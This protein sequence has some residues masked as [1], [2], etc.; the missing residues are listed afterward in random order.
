VTAALVD[1]TVGLDP[2][3]VSARTRAEIARRLVDSIACAVGAIDAEPVV[4]LR[5]LAATRPLTAGSAVWG[6]DSPTTPEVAALANATAIRFLDYSDYTVGGHPSDNIAAVVAA[7][8]WAERPVA[9]LVAGVLV[10]YE[11]FGELGKLM[12]RYRG[13]DQGTTAVIAA[14]CGVGKALGLTP[15]QQASAI[16]MVA[17]GNIAT[18]KSRRGQLT[19]WKGVAGPYA[20]SCAVLAAQMAGAGVTAPQDAFE[21]EFGFWQQVSGPFE[22]E[23][24]DPGGEPHHLFRAASKHWP[25]QFDLQPAV[26]LG[27]RIGQEAPVADVVGIDVEASEWT[28]KG[29]AHDPA[30]WAPET[31]ETADHSLPFVLALALHRRGVRHEDFTEE[32]ITSETHRRT[33]ATV[34]V[35]AA[36]D[37]TAATAEHCWMRAVVTLVDGSTRSVEVK[38]PRATHLTDA[39]LREKWELL[40]RGSRLE[41]GSVGL[42][43]GLVELRPDRSV[44]ELLAS[45]S[46]A[47]GR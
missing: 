13:W 44:R 15:D 25:V 29:T 47:T 7:C 9:D 1:Y 45:L 37:I 12:V 35:R 36:D 40:V 11:V 34:R 26:W 32:N 5:R 43:A 22:I 46:P 16:G 39:E 8:E 4:A 3:R 21:G 20:A 19:A 38:Q 14:V 27:V 18:V 17:T 41:P 23:H 42:L 6:A 10:S 33:M 30:Q 28:W 24:L 31:R 2:D